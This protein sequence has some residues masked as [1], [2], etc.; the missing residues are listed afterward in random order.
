M[1]L[2][3]KSSNN[4]FITCYLMLDGTECD[5]PEARSYPLATPMARRTA[6]ATAC[7]FGPAFLATALGRQPQTPCLATACKSSQPRNC[8]NPRSHATSQLLHPGNHATASLSSQPLGNCW[9][10]LQQRC[11]QLLPLSANHQVEDQ[12]YEPIV[13]VHEAQEDA[14]RVHCGPN[15]A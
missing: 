9:H 1:C 5:A 11:W 12:T 10:L 15:L 8:L 13:E 14:R 4:D 7:C 3:Y 6:T 2:S